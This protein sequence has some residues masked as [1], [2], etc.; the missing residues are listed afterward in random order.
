MHQPGLAGFGLV[1]GF[2]SGVTRHRNLIINGERNPWAHWPVG[3]R[4]H[5][6]PCAVTQQAHRSK[7]ARATPRSDRIAP[8]PMHW[9]RLA[10]RVQIVDPPVLNDELDEQVRDAPRL[11]LGLFVPVTV[12]GI[13]L[14]E[15]F[16][17]FR[18]IA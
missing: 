5:R 10:Q 15:V 13:H 9:R 1:G 6:C 18:Y 3:P 14:D 2:L 8:G 11:P 12:L 7:L 4:P 16:R 17:K